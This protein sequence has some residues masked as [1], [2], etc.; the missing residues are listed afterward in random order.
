MKYLQTGLFGK[1]PNVVDDLGSKTVE[2]F[3]KVKKA[4]D[5]YDSAG[6]ATDRMDDCSSDFCTKFLNHPDYLPRCAG[7]AVNKLT[8]PL[9]ALKD[10]DP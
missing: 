5:A 3:K 7:C 4:Y 8:H 1:L 2:G 9:D 10:D 6:K